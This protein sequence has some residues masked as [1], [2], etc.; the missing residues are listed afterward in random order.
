MAEY[1]RIKDGTEKKFLFFLFECAPCHTELSHSPRRCITQ[2][3]IPPTHGHWL[4][5]PAAIL[6]SK[7]VKVKTKEGSHRSKRE[8]EKERRTYQNVRTGLFCNRDVCFNAY[9]VLFISSRNVTRIHFVGP[10][11]ARYSA[12]NALTSSGW[13]GG[14]R[15]RESKQNQQMK[16]AI[17]LKAI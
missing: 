4:V 5:K 2:H 14:L 9:N 1:N 8:R 13:E 11:L 17:D 10:P 7:Q 15:E 6:S 16:S 3:L 12:L